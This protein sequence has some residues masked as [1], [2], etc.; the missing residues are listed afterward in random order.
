MTEKGH[1]E[2][3]GYRGDRSTRDG[4]DRINSRSYMN[5]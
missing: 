2:Y 4:K 5:E 3:T 1:R